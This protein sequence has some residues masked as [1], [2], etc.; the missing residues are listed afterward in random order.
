M[1]TTNYTKFEQFK[2]VIFSLSLPLKKEDI[3]AEQFLLERLEEKNLSIYYAPVEY[4]NEDASILIVGITPGFRQMLLAYSAAIQAKSKWNDNEKILHQAKMA[5][6]YEGPMRK[7]LIR[8]LD[9]LKLHEYL[10]IPSSAALFGSANHF[11]HTTGLVPYPVFHKNKNFTGSNPSILRTDMLYNYA[12]E[13]FANDVSRLKKPIIIPLGVTVTKVLS[14]LANK[15]LLDITHM[16]TGFPHPS[17]AN[18][19][20]YKQFARNKEMMQKELADYF[21]RF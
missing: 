4:F 21:R 5:S 19:H 3:V 13:Y 2:D 18:A 12:V 15:N 1:G 14:H 10:D 11:V 16:L 7:N 8:M 6:S 20:R 9:E 17:G